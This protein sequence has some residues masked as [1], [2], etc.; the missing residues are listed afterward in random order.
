MPMSVRMESNEDIINFRMKSITITECNS[1]DGHIMRC[2]HTISEDNSKVSKYLTLNIPSDNERIVYSAGYNN[3]VML[4]SPDPPTNSNGYFSP[5]YGA[6]VIHDTKSWKYIDLINLNR[7]FSVN[8]ADTICRQMGYTHSVPNSAILL[9]ESAVIFNF[10][11]LDF[12]R[13][14]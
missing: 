3:E 5:S 6:V 2:E 12:R 11:Y 4:W 1:T 14:M 9:N 13:N 8:V 10:N 7:L